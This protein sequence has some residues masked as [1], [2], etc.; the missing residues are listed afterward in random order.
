[1]LDAIKVPTTLDKKEDPTVFCC[2]LF[3]QGCS[4]Q[5]IESVMH[6]NVG[7]KYHKETEISEKIDDL[8]EK[9]MR[10]IRMLR[11]GE[12][13]DKEFEEL[14]KTV[15]TL[16]ILQRSERKTKESEPSS[17]RKKLERFVNW[18]K[19]FNLDN[20]DNLQ[21]VDYEHEGKG[22]K[23]TK[24]IKK[25]D[26]VTSIPATLVLTPLA[27][28]NEGSPLHNF[29]SLVLDGA[30]KIQLVV[31][32]L[33][34]RFTLKSFWGPY[35]DLLPQTFHT[36]LNWAWEEIL[37]I[38]DT[39]VLYVNVIEQWAHVAFHYC[40]TW[41]A[42]DPKKYD[43]L[44]RSQLT[45]ENWVWAVNV[46]LSRQNEI[47]ILDDEKSSTL[48]SDRS[49]QKY[50]QPDHHKQERLHEK[51]SV[52]NKD[53]AFE[54]MAKVNETQQ[55]NISNAVQSF[56][57]EEHQKEEP[58][59][60]EDQTNQEHL[61]ISAKNSASKDKENESKPPAFKV[62]YGLIPVFDLFNHEYASEFSGSYDL[63]KKEVELLAGRD[64]KKDEQV[65]MFY[66]PRPNY[67]LL[68]NQGF[69]TDR[70]PNDLIFIAFR[71]MPQHDKFYKEKC[72][73]MR[74]I[75]P[76][77]TPYSSSAIISNFL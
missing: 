54:T 56:K 61:H 44:K 2:L 32:L 73:I 57:A 68:L 10:T 15:Q 40:A 60:A 75:L 36:P 62:T 9:S 37:L 14:F 59:L 64:F 12:D 67:Q 30:D 29:L 70:N 74:Q 35:I 39:I 21:I 27:K 51:D 49:S 25:G 45:W 24:N 8:F 47:R 41:R 69:L 48:C 76:E 17:E 7:T 42:L 72:E 77:W 11:A 20:W 55:K 26:K 1:M 4:A 53:T 66:G 3:F 71:T 52:S 19:G 43:F 18:V 31:R 58:H 22:I 13:V 6:S 50:N 28:L 23:T 34:E 5:K 33:V 16:K 46:V 38:K 65:R 63:E